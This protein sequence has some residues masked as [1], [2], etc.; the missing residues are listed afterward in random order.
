MIH[1]THTTPHSTVPTR[2]DGRMRHTTKELT[3]KSLDRSSF[4]VQ[5]DESSCVA[6]TAL[7]RQLCAA[8][9]DGAR[10]REARGGRKHRRVGDA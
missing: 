8:G 1:I 9:E 6:L 10:E 7:A 3:N 2:N 5:S 4:R